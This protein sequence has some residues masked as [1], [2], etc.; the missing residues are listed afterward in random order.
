[1]AVNTDTPDGS[2]IFFFPGYVNEITLLNPG[3]RLYKS[4]GYTFELQPIEAPR[5][6]SV[7]GRMTRSMSRNAAMDI[8]PPPPHAFHGYA[9]YALAGGMAG[10]SSGQRAN[11]D[12]YIPQPEVGGSSW[13]SAGS[14][15]W[16]QAAR[17]NWTY[18]SS[19]SSGGAPPFFAARRTFSA[20]G[21]RDLTQGFLDL[22]LRVGNMD[23]RT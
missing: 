18:G 5:R 11:W 3:L 20:R 21:Y 1:M 8:T 23:E 19:S 6:S 12:Q 16:D 14:I 10:S 13:Q 7:S 17:A 15:E 2:I 4:H 9:G 22:N